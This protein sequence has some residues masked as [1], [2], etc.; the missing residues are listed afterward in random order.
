[1]DF[2]KHFELGWRNTVKYIG[3]AILLTFIQ[4]VA[5][6]ATLGILGPVTYA[7]YVRSMLLAQREGREPNVKDLFSEMSLFL[8]LLV[9]SIAVLIAIGFGLMLLVIPGFLVSLFIAFACLY[10]VPIMVDQRLGI[11]DAVKASWEMAVRKPV[12]DQGIITVVFLALFSIGGTILPV[13]L[14]AQPLAIFIMLS[15]YEKRLTSL[16]EVVPPPPPPG[17]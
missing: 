13:M 10:V 15:V 7:G 11:W 1:M 14:I 3:P 5:T 8:P 2:A 17:S 6:V 16:S 4:W 9:F 12:A